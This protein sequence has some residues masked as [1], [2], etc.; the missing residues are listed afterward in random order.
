MM[1]ESALNAENEGVNNIPAALKLCAWCGV[2]PRFLKCYCR[3]CKSE[4]DRLEKKARLT[5]F[6]PENSP[7][8]FL[9]V[10]ANPK[11][12]IL[13]YLKAQKGNH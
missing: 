13:T 4:K 2:K 12:K 5:S 11:S 3:E 6:T 10:E 8:M 1:N 7:E 9:P